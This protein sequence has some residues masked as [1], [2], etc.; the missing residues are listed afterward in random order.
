MPS[1]PMSCRIVAGRKGSGK[2]TAILSL[3]D[4]DPSSAGYATVS[5]DG[6]YFLRRL[7]TGE[8]NLL[9]EPYGG[10]GERFRRWHI[11]EGAFEEADS[12]LRSLSGKSIYIDEIGML[13]VAGRGFADALGALLAA[14]E[15]VTIAVRSDYL[16][17]VSSAFGIED[18][19]IIWV[20]GLS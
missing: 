13:E 19:E 5:R 6:C 11:M 12:Y 9:L 10:T 8:E 4:E 14:G 20:E 7:P 3:S 18:A 2:T 15:D 16:E 1:S 17:E